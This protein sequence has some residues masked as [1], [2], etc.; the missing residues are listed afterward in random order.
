MSTNPPDIVTMIGEQ[1]SALQARRAV[2]VDE[3]ELIDSK[4]AKIAAQ[5]GIE[6]P[7]QGSPS[8]PRLPLPQKSNKRYEG[9]LPETMMGLLLE[10]DRGYSR[11]ELKAA[12]L[13]TAAAPTV[14]KNE[15]TFYNAVKRYIKADKLVEIEGLLYHPNRAPLEEDDGL[16]ST[17]LPANVTLFE[18][19]KTATDQ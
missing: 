19:K 16:D 2:L 10:A 4:M 1:L 5:L 6:L 17:R 9:S 12:L 8:L 7:E 3:V 15:N 11:P 14:I 13:K 18:Q